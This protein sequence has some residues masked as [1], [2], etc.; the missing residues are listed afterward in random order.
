MP[1][2]NYREKI[3]STN[4][5]TPHQLWKAASELKNA[6]IIKDPGTK[7][8]KTFIEGVTGGGMR[9]KAAEKRVN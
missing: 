8:Q 6:T 7:V 5:T 3:G 9:Q 4:A 2:T 1:L